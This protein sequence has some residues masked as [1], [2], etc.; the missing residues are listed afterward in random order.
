MYKKNAQ[1]D[2]LPVV[3][4]CKKTATCRFFVGGATQ[5]WRF[6]WVGTG[7]RLVTG[8]RTSPSMDL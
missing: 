8:I 4:L 6:C 3:D 2:V 5:V 7:H 1:V